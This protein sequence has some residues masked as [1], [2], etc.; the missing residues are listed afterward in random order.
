MFKQDFPSLRNS[1]IAYLDSAASAQKPQPVINA[2]SHIMSNGYANI[3]RGLYGWS[4]DITQRYE[5]TRGLVADFIGCKNTNEI[6]FTRNATE[7]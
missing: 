4:Q 5:E 7:S 2:M 6:V 3:H 1:N